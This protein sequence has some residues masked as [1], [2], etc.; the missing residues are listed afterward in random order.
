MRAN[1]RFV[2]VSIHAI[3]LLCMIG[4]EGTE[5][6]GKYISVAHLLYDIEFQ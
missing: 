5:D 2:V 6:P 4:I 3:M 1:V